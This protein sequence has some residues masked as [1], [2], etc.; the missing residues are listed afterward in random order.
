MVFGKLRRLLISF[1]SKNSII[2]L[3]YV[4]GSFIFKEEFNVDR[5]PSQVPSFPFLHFETTYLNFKYIINVV[6]GFI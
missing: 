5:D 1:D 6:R 2:N 4:G 3:S